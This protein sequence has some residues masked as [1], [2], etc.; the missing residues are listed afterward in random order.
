M[1]TAYAQAVKYSFAWIQTYLAVSPDVTVKEAMS[2]ITTGK[3]RT[4]KKGYMTVMP[5][6]EQV[7]H[8]AFYR[9]S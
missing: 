4:A 1:A 7:T 3:V 9:I 6:E 2:M 8:S 5:T